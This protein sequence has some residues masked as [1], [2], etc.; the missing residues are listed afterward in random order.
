AAVQWLLRVPF[1]EALRAVADELRGLS[2]ASSPA[3]PAAGGKT[4]H[5][6]MDAVVGAVAWGLQQNQRLHE[7]PKPANVWTYYNAAGAEVGAVVR[8]DLAAGKEIRQLR[9]EGGGWVSSAM[10]EPRPLYGLPLV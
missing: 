4:I 2:R 8:W 10:N 7:K 1:T 6:T 3:K 5:Q 9:V